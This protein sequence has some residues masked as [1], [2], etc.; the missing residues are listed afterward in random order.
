MT[1]GPDP[2]QD[3]DL[4]RIVE[5]VVNDPRL[6]SAL[7]D[8]LSRRRGF[9]RQL[10][11]AMHAPQDEDVLAEPGPP[12]GQSRSGATPPP[13]RQPQA[14]LDRSVVSSALI[15]WLEVNR[16]PGSSAAGDAF[17]VI[18]DLNL[19]HSG[20]RQ[21]TAAQLQALITRVAPGAHVNSEKSRL[22]PQYLFVTLTR[23]E[24][25]AVVQADAD[26]GPGVYDAPQSQRQ[27]TMHRVWPDFPLQATLHK[28]CAT[29]KAEAARVSFAAG[30]QDIVWAVL[31]SGIDG[32]HPHFKFHDN[33]AV[34]P[35]RHQDFTGTGDPLK[36]DFGHGTHVAGIIAGE[37]PTQKDSDDPQWRAFHAMVAFRDDQED[38]EYRELPL[39]RLSGVAP[40]CKL[41]SYKVLDATGKGNV[42]NLLAAIAQLQ[43]VNGNGK[44]LQIHGVNISIGHGFD[45]EWF[46]CGQSPLCVEVDRLVRSG[47]VV[48]VAAGN[49][50]YGTVSSKLLGPVATTLALTINDPGNAELAIT[51]GA[52]HRE[53]PHQYGV[54]Y[55]SS[56]GPTGDGRLKP[57]LVA[58]GERV[59]SCAAGSK[60]TELLAKGKDAD[61]L[62]DSGTSMAAPHVSGA[63]AAFL[64]VQREF[65]GRPEEVKRILMATATDLGRHRDFQGAGMVDV[66]RAIQSV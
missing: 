35:L 28:T 31:D 58:P 52:V 3:E 6:L 18:V 38:I 33:L 46:A 23:D 19:Q 37:W 66:M 30:G 13:A 60:K 9:Q 16:A 11:D 15:D 24:L 49:T 57:D 27:R 62:E 63:A 17:P 55:F 39:P 65:I 54:S 1:E 14:V 10:A 64:S 41:V 59:L 25:T 7:V 21:D 45:P 2:L 43:E 51:V 56:K 44:L 61:Y 47:V 20:T 26:P 22:L 8:R 50:G 48:V 32:Q 34:E 42:S 12:L 53:S 5:R 4:T 36:D 40:Q 29:I